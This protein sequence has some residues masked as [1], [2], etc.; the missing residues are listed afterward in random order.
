MSEGHIKKEGHEKGERDNRTAERARDITARN[1][2]R[3]R[4]SEEH[5]KEE[6][7]E[8]HK[9]ELELVHAARSSG[10]GLGGAATK[11]W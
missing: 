2:R 3:A 7:K 6:H 9:G 1:I 10:H 5:K 8:Q 4:A 11:K